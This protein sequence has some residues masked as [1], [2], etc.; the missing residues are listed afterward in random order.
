M[1]PEFVKS[2][3]E[4]PAKAVDYPGFIVSRILDIIP[5]YRKI[6]FRMVAPAVI[7]VIPKGPAD[8]APNRYASIK[9]GFQGL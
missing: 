2:F 7:T 9:P 4:I 6:R 3:G 8:A 1:T 5:N